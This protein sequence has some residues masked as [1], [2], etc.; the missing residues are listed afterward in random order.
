MNDLVLSYDAAA[1]A[2]P[3]VVG[4]KGWNLGR[5][6]RYGF[7]VPAGG[8]LV[9]EVYC[10]FMAAPALEALRA[11]LRGIREEDVGTPSVDAGL[12]ALRALI[13]AT[14]LPAAV[15][16]Q[17]S[18]FLSASGL[19]S[20][21]VAVRSSATAED[22]AMAS[23]AGVH[24]SFLGILGVEPVLQ[25]V[26]G[27][28]ASLW[29][30]EALAYRRRIGL[31]DE[32]VA[33]AVV[34][35]GMVRGRGSAPPLAAGVA[36]S[37]D[38]R[39]GRRDQVAISAAPGLGE[40]VVG[41]RINPEEITVS[42]DKAPWKVNRS[43]GLSQQVLTDEPALELAR[44][45]LRVQWALG[46]GQDPQ[47]IEWAHDGSRF[48]L[49]Q[50]RPVTRP[51]HV[52]FPAVRRLPVIWSNGN[53]KDAVPG[54]QSTLSWSIIQSILRVILF[55]GLEAVRYPLPRGME[56]VRRITGRAHF[57]L[58]AMQWAYY[59]A[60]GVLPAETNRLTGGHQPEIPV[61]PES[62]FRGRRGLRR[63]ARSLQF[64]RLLMRAARELPQDILRV[65]AAARR[66]KAVDVSRAS[67]R[68]LLDFL[69]QV[70]ETA[71]EFGPRFILA[72]HN[73]GAWQAPLETVLRQ[74]AP[75][76]ASSLA[77]AL[78]AGGGQ[79]TSA[80][81]GYRLFDLAAVARQDPAARACLN[82]TPLDPQGWRQLPAGSPFRGEM[83]KFLDEFGHR[84]VY[85]A[86][87]ANPRWNEDPGYLLEQIR[88]L[89]DVGPNRSPQEAARAVRAAAEAEVARSTWLL[90]PVVRWLAGQARQGAAL[91]E[92]AK[93]ALAALQEP[94]RLAYLE[95]GRRLVATGALEAPSDV[96]HLAWVDLESYMRDE[97]DG[98]GAQALVV[99][100]K[101]QAAAWSAEDP[102]DVLV[103]DADGRATD[104]PV[105]LGVPAARE[106]PAVGRIAD[107]DVWIGIGVSAGSASGPAR[108]LRHPSEGRRLRPGDVLVAPSTDP[109]WTPLFL[110][111]S[112][113]VME[114][115]GY[116]SHG[117]IVAREYAIPAVVNIPGLLDAVRDGQ[118]IIMD[119]D[120]GQVVLKAGE[121]PE[122]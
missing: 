18:R 72:N 103:V 95:I 51:P 50:A 25:A 107:G 46:D 84:G 75:W 57:D 90:R 88:L 108:I 93:S 24:R 36:F 64:I 104:L 53:I 32:Q 120:A 55:A 31:S 94:G 22:S 114:V 11:G 40:A 9:A 96:F 21:P 39:T 19:V 117:A 74:V 47:D 70:S 13:E 3:S 4:G 44:L 122:R 5:L 71:A 27:C 60:M 73:A 41:G 56:T 82:Q 115:G 118:P 69:Q 116:L 30:P 109:G 28:Y 48:W 111:A 91:R 7:P 15:G 76:R 62:P 105:P 106:A 113:V 101:A 23:F 54:V 1:V 61:P 83:E 89:M 16:S 8:V 97:W 100:R 59:D 81:H 67:R 10:E 65:H 87:I 42:V 34:I 121:E 6:H 92:A 2:G 17:V 52:T 110:R 78:L 37:C 35:C 77:T 68:G 20:V 98:A 58:T 14:P 85:E 119:G 102:P 80:E 63:L 45:A 38:P 66:Q 12:A 99:D 26:K 86:E 29:T 112:A 79:V 43:R 49:L 33:C